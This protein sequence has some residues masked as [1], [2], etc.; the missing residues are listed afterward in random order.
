MQWLSGVDW[1]IE[2]VTENLEIKKALFR[3]KGHLA[4][5]EAGVFGHRGG[6]GGN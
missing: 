1:I 4:K 2:V 6:K 3:R 5:H